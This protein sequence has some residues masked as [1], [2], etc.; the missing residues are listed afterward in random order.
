M[1]QW[2]HTDELHLFYS[3]NVINWSDYKNQIIA[4]VI[5]FRIVENLRLSCESIFSPSTN[6]QHLYL[7]TRLTIAP[8]HLSIFIFVSLII[9]LNILSLCLSASQCHS[10]GRRCLSKS[11][12]TTHCVGK[13]VSHTHAHDLGFHGNRECSISPP[14]LRQS[15]QLLIRHSLTVCLLWPLTSS[16]LVACNPCEGEDDP[17]LWN[18]PISEPRR[19]CRTAYSHQLPEISNLQ[20]SAARVQ[21]VVKLRL[22]ESS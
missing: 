11:Y 12:A 19:A 16:V 3:I 4:F 17:F 22:S 5:R 21:L 8:S 14:A 9:N 10:E 2:A 18:H 6:S 13:W 7:S 1:L 20:P 15:L